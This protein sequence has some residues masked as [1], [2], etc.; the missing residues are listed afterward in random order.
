METSY[1]FGNL[2][3]IHSVSVNEVIRVSVGVKK[4]IE[5]AGILY[6]QEKARIL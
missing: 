3:S 1:L 4:A 5:G 2:L 6:R